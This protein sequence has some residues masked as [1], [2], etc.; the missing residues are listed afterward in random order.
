MLKKK[1]NKEKTR[2]PDKLDLIPD[3]LFKRR[4][5]QGNKTNLS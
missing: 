5:K 1:K 4:K 2:K 3:K